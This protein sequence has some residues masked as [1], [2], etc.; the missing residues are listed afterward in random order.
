MFV[1]DNFQPFIS[2]QFHK[3]LLLHHVALPCVT[4]FTFL[5]FKRFNK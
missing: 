1:F 5:L 2:I 3:E 4:V